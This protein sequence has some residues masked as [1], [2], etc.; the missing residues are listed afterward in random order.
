MK[1]IHFL[2]I[3][4]TMLNVAF[5]QTDIKQPLSIGDHYGGGIIFSLDPSSQHGLIAA[6]YDQIDRACW[7][8]TRTTNATYMNEG[9]LNTEKIVEREEKVF[10]PDCK[11]PAACYC[12]SLTLGGFNDWYL[13]SINELK[14]MYDKQALIGGF[15]AWDYCSSTESSEGKCW[16]IHFRPNKRVIYEDSKNYKSFTVRCIRKF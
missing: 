16:N 10:L 14:E 4:F 7:G 6:P 3:G 2:I 9:A 1:T 12:D 8:N 13:P 5:G 15:V 11:Y